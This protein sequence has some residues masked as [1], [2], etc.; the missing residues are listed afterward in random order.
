MCAPSAPKAKSALNAPTEMRADVLTLASMNST[1]RSEST[2]SSP[3]R[4]SIASA[5]LE[6]G[7]LGPLSDNARVIAK[8]RVALDAFTPLIAMMHA[9][10]LQD[11]CTVSRT[12][13]ELAT[14]VV[15][16]P[17]NA[18]V[19]EA[20]TMAL[21]EMNA[22]T[23]SSEVSA[24]RACASTDLVTF[25]S[26]RPPSEPYVTI[27]VISDENA[28]G[29]PGGGGGWGDGGGF[30]GGGGGRGGDG[31]GGAGGRAYSV[32]TVPP[33]PLQGSQGCSV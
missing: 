10:L 4:G 26:S 1:E 3:I 23:C 18:T 24:A 33:T 30:G 21:V 8:L 15:S 2:T 22:D 9:W 31:G 13:A 5:R 27:T 32:A 7:A 20:D 19:T 28:R 17:M 29:D 16:L 6:S 11:P 25:A 14:L 12:S